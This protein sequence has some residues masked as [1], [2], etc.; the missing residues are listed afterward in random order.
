MGSAPNAKIRNKTTRDRIIRAVRLG[1]THA[2]AAQ[3]GGIGRRTLYDWLDRGKQAPHGVYR[4]FYDDFHQA[5][6]AG[7]EMALAVIAKAARGGQWQAAG[8]LLERRYGFRREAH[9]KVEAKVNH[10]FNDDDLIDELQDLIPMGDE[11]EE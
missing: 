10:T 3:A 6:A 1:A 4:E 9:V 5:E 8:W 11:G 2:L 7:A